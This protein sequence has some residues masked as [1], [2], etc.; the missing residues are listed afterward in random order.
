M[1][2]SI[3]AI[4]PLSSKRRRHPAFDDAREDARA[5]RQNAVIED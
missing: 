5:D 3:S 4:R 2:E 1:A